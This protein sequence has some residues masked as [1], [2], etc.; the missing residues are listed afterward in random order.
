MA[1]TWI[2][3]IFFLYYAKNHIIY[4]NILFSI[5]VSL[6]NSQKMYIFHYHILELIAYYIVSYQI[7]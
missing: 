2:Q 6:N 4:T 5:I 1:V 3:P 7:Y